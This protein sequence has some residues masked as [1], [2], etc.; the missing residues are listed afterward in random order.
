VHADLPLNT[1]IVYLKFK[2]IK[3]VGPRDFV[4]ISK[5]KKISENKS[6]VIIKSIALDTKPEV[7]NVKRGDMYSESG[8]VIESKKG[9]KKKDR[10]LVSYVQ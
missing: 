10:C 3:A 6:I 4:L 7:E 8:W 2:K 1:Q 9:G 5:S